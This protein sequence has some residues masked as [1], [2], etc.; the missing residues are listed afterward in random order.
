MVHDPN[1]RLFSKRI[2]QRSVQEQPTKYITTYAFYLQMIKFPKFA[3]EINEIM[4]KQKLTPTIQLLGL[5]Y[6]R[7]IKCSKDVFSCN[8]II[9]KQLPWL[10]NIQ[11]HSHWLCFNISLLCTCSHA[12]LLF[13][14]HKNLYKNLC[15]K[16]LSPFFG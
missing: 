7:L 14:L 13:L 5:I 8:V 6:I 12:Q 4:K 1:F 2:C 11:M 16:I 9:W 15:K 10:V 3:W